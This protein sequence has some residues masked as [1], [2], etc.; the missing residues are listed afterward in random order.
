MHV[1][2]RIY[3]MKKKKKEKIEKKQTMNG[4]FFICFWTDFFLVWRR[5]VGVFKFNLTQLSCLIETD[6]MERE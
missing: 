6:E 5:K 4:V 2:E 3:L 1:N